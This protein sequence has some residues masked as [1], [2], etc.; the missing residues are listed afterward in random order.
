VE[1]LGQAAQSVARLL[2]V[3]PQERS[4]RPQLPKLNSSQTAHDGER[5]DGEAGGATQDRLEFRP[6]S[7]SGGTLLRRGFF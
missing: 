7:S 2:E 5:D 4:P 6:A 1:G 3:T